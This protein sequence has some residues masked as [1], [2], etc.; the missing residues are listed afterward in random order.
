MAE[1]K[2]LAERIIVNRC[3]SDRLFL[4]RTERS[5]TIIEMR[6][7]NIPILV[8][9][10]GKKLSQHHRRVRRPIAVMPAVQSPDGTEYCDLEMSVSAC[11]EDHTLLAALVDRPVTDQPH[12]TLDKI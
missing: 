4:Q 6:D 3:F 12:V 8:L 2:L 10:P 11:S 5:N 7:E 1:A 9:H